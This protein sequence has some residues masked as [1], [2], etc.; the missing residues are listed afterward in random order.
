MNLN[1]VYFLAQMPGQNI[2]PQAPGEFASKFDNI[3]NLAM[4]I[5]IAIAIIGVIVA[6]A[7]MVI[8]RQQGSSEEATSMAL[9]I[10]IGSMIIGAAGTI[11]AA[12][13]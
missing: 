7:S 1:P 8:S 10:G 3:L 12:M 5:G 11:V 9:R 4:Y 2:Q 13:L 6:G